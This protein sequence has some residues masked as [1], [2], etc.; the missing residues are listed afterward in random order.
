[1]RYHGSMPAKVTV[2]PGDRYGRW[3]VLHEES[4]TVRTD[5]GVR[6]WFTCVCNC[7]VERLVGLRSLRSG[8]A[9]CG[10]EFKVSRVGPSPVAVPVGTR[11]GTLTVL[12]EGERCNDSRMRRTLRCQCDCGV[13]KELRL[14]SLRSGKT[15]SCG[16]SQY[17]HLR[18]ESVIPGVKGLST[19]SSEYQRRVHLWINFGITLERY[20]AMLTAQGGCCAVCRRSASEFP[21]AF[22]VDHD[23]ACCPGKKTC[24]NCVR[25]LLCPNCNKNLGW[26]EKVGTPAITSYLLDGKEVMPDAFCYDK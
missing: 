21:R 8:S 26:V 5:R 19:S 3:T 7:G 17:D 22:H 6:R 16:C 13:I 12:G 14:D 4:T 10:C 15:Q 25:G 20:Q 1:M 23:H 18:V 11:F 24:G 2:S 9:S